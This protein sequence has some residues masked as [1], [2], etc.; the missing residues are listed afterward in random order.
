MTKK[1]A[2]KKTQPQRHG[3]AA[4]LPQKAEP[5][6][7]A[8]DRESSSRPTPPSENIHTTPHHVEPGANEPVYWHPPE[9][10]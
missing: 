5:Q 10:K 8:E 2:R 1:Q 7:R 3:I 6:V 4:S 9:K